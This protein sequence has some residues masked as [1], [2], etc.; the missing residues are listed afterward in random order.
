MTPEARLQ[1]LFADE[2]PP[3]RD[4][5]FEAE[6]ARRVA[7]RRAVL[8]VAALLPLAVAFGVLLWAVRPYLA[9]LT[10]PAAAVP[11]MTAGGLAMVGALM[12]VWMSGRFSAA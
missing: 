7:A 6:V 2:T 10:F 1:A 8:R 5:A 4:L 9:G 11:A 3:P 12:L